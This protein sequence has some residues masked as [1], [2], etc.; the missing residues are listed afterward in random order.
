MPIHFS[1]EYSHLPL[2]T[3][4]ITLRIYN[5]TISVFHYIQLKYQLTIISQNTLA[6]AALAM[7]LTLVYFLETRLK[8]IYYHL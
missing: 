8:K 2:S 4:H 3:L 5:M 7:L 1:F 6:I